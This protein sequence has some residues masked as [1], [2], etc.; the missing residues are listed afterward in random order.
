MSSILTTIKRAPPG[1]GRPLPI[2]TP[3]PPGVPPSLVRFEKPKPA[4]G[5]SAQNGGKRNKRRHITKKRRISKKGKT[6]RRRK[7][8]RI[9]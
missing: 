8:K 6:N 2:G 9:R 1:F 4:P 3:I 7:S 5:A